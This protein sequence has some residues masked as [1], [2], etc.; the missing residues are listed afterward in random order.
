MAVT[1]TSGIWVAKPGEEDEFVAAWEEF[2]RWA[3]THDGAG[4]LR[5]VRDREQTNRFSSF[6]PWE[7]VDAI[8]AWKGSDEFRER[9]GQVKQHVTEFSPSE[10]ELVAEV[11]GQAAA[12]RA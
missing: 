4:T 8:Q 6:A 9:I 1:Y 5:L 11:A 2:A 3:S 10:L 7:S 12:V